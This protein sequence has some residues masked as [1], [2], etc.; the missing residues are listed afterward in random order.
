[1]GQPSVNPRLPVLAATS[2][3]QE[4]RQLLA[5]AEGDNEIFEVQIVASLSEAAQVLQADRRFLVLWLDGDA[6]DNPEVLRDLE[7]PILL[8]AADCAYSPESISGTISPAALA[9]EHRQADGPGADAA[10]GFVPL[11]TAAASEQ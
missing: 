3:A 1:M 9:L 5:P 6:I 2:N 10:T 4:V 11:P 7:L 8:C